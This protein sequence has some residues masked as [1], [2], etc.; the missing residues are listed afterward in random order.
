MEDTAMKKEYINP[1]MQMVNLQHQ[2][3]ICQSTNAY[4]MNISLQ[5]EDVESA[6]TKENNGPGS[7]SG[8]WDDEW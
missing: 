5:S 8:V 2:H 3:I 1:T 4:G 6:W 7:S